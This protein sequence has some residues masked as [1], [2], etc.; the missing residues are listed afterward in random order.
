MA[1]YQS[2]FLLSFICNSKDFSTFGSDDEGFGGLIEVERADFWSN[3]GDGVQVDGCQHGKACVPED[4]LAV[5]SSTYK[6]CAIFN[7]NNLPDRSS[8]SWVNIS[9]NVASVRLLL[10]FENISG[11]ISSETFSTL[12]SIS[13]ASVLLKTASLISHDT[14]LATDILSLESEELSH[15]VASSHE[16]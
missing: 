1:L 4:Q 15:F 7:A 5:T 2:R 6:L 11:L 3:G 8:M 13:A 9:E 16:C 10:P 12:E 14:F